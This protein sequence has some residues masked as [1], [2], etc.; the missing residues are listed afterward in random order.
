MRLLASTLFAAALLLLPANDSCGQDWEHDVQP[1]LQENC[2][3]CHG[4]AKQKGELDLRS[5]ESALRGG[6][7]GPA[8]V[9]QKP[10]ESLLIKVLDAEADPHMPPKKQLAAEDIA[11][12]RSWI[13][14]LGAGAEAGVKATADKPAGFELPAGVDVSLATDLFIQA[15]WQATGITAAS[16]AD[17]VTFVRRV[18]LD[19]LGRIP[20]RA[21]RDAF[22]AETDSDKR[23][24]LIDRLTETADY[25]AHLAEIFDVVFLGRT[26]GKRNERSQWRDYLRWTFAT[27]RPWDRV[28]RDLLVARPASELEGGASWFLYE[29]RD[30]HQKMATLASASLLGKQVQCAQCH[31][32]P[33][34]P[35]IEQR[36][37]WGLVS[38]FSRSLNVKTP[39]GPRVAE[40]ASGGYAKFSNLEGES[41]ETELVM[42][43]GQR[44]EEPDGRRDQDQPELYEV[45]PPD[46]WFKQLNK[47]EKL[48]KDLGALPVPKFSRREEFA[49]ATTSGNPDF[50]RAI[51]NR[52]WAIVF[53]RGLVHPVDQMDSAHPPSHPQLLDW[54]ANDFAE[55][56]HDVR[57]LIRGLMKTRAYQLD[58]RAASS[59]DDTDRPAEDRWFARALDK[60]LSAEALYRSMRIAAGHGSGEDE[61]LRAAFVRTFPALFA[62][63]YSPSVQQ[64]MFVANGTLVDQLLSNSAPLVQTL[65]NLQTA[66][67]IA[68]EAFVQ[69]LGREP[70]AE[71]QARCIDFLKREN[72]PETI[73]Q[74]CWALLAGAEFR[75]NH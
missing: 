42:L 47:D 17:D 30:D 12:L 45:A 34:S 44:V 10:G 35:E 33:V 31:D 3:K 64:A 4:G 7:S 16:R 28:G 61:N 71:E 46:Q 18:F 27:N 68:D 6:E 49:K 5:T 48:Q 37:Y 14:H 9:P 19:L 65:T 2:T 39:D 69:I 55:N 40:R 41:S 62:D 70:D 73:R 32:H 20:T 60:P 38:F 1:L 13:A 21:E 66:T 63:V 50:S 54:L 24:A 72:Q 75:I 58:S 43:T 56:G 36:H 23:A 26:D 59:N 53:G 8:I 29:Q 51:V 15:G 67:A 74:L 52:V 25:A 57:R 11:T 22:L